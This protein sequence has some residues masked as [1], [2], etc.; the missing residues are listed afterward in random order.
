MMAALRLSEDATQET[1]DPFF[2]SPSPLCV[3]V[4]AEHVT[5]S[6]PGQAHAATEYLNPG[7][8]KQTETNPGGDADAGDRYDG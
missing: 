7:L 2:L 4:D 6:S 5:A 1:A 3:C 8:I